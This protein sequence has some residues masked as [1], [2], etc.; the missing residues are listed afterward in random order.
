MEEQIPVE[1]STETTE[2][3]LLLKE[4]ENLPSTFVA[5]FFPQFAEWCWSDAVTYLTQAEI[6]LSRFILFIKAMTDRVPAASLPLFSFDQVVIAAIC[7][8]AQVPPSFMD[9]FSQDRYLEGMAILNSKKPP[10]DDLRYKPWLV[11]ETMLSSF[12]PKIKIVSH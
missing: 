4:Y 8:T 11:L 5:L 1:R 9:C 6:P 10:V 3:N 12:A 7:S 2:E